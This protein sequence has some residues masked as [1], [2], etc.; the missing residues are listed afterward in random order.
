MTLLNSMDFFSKTINL[1]A[2][3]DGIWAKKHDQNPQGSQDLQR[4][5]GLQGNVKTLEQWGYKT[6]PSRPTSLGVL[7]RFLSCRA[8]WPGFITLLFQSSYFSLEVLAKSF[9]QGSLR[10]PIKFHKATYGFQK[11][12]HWI[13]QGEP[14]DFKRKSIAS[15]C[16]C[17]GK[18]ISKYW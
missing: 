12:I 7:A 10:K 14:M 17:V 11:E 18:Q 3:I 1:F 13:E 9:Y 4:I 6:E 2:K 16:I 8:A 5:R 15:W